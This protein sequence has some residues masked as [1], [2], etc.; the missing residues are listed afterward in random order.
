MIYE[1]NTSYSGKVKVK[2]SVELYTVKDFMGKEMPGL[3][4]RLTD[5]DTLEP[6]SMLTKSFGEFIGI[7][8]AAYIDTNNCPY[9]NQLLEKGI[10]TATPIKKASGRCEYPLWIF[11]KEF[12]LEHGE[13]NYKKYSDSYDEY[14]KPYLDEVEET[15]ENQEMGGM[16][17]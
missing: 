12:L 8:N 4:I 14:M 15:D 7:K 13:E 3:A 6:F 10:A 11:N 2:P 9:A 5:A 17:Q 1:I 16:K